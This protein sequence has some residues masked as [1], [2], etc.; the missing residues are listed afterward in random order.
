MRAMDYRGR[1]APSPTGDL[2]GGSLVAALGS[3]LR[4]RQAGGRWLVRMDD[5]DPPREVP[6]AAASILA[7]L[8][9]FGLEPDEPV[10]F[11]S[12]RDDAYREAFE[13]LRERGDLF[14][15]WCS[16]ND[17]AAHEDGLHRDGKCVSAPREDRPPAW[18]LR[19][20][21]RDIGFEDRL[22]GPQVQ[23]LRRDVGDF[24]IRRGDG[25]WSYHLACVVDDAFQGISEVVRGRDLLDSTPRQVY[26]QQRLD[27]PT[28][29]YL[30]LPLA[31]RADAGKLSKSTR[32][33]PLDP[34]RPL[35]DL[36]RALRILGIGGA[37]A[38]EV[39]TLL[40]SAID[41]FDP[42]CIRPRDQAVWTF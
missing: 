20:P 33:L 13:H 17:L 23:N 24:V 9:A 8:R 41:A 11:Q 38:S 16:R 39:Q 14:P 34:T 31:L 12:R 18:R 35:P 3:W 42:A 30:H 7:T 28:P 27:L 32:D 36:R 29:A 26:L 37:G 5:L 25:I 2:H 6:G 4:A 40:Q 15:C 19:V 1:F 10:L 21:D 22:Q